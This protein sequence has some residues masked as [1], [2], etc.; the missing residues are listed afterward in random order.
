MCRRNQLRG[1]L[2]LGIGIGMVIGYCVNSWL[3]C[4]CG[5][6]A[7]AVTAVCMMKNGI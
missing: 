4:C 7:L 3:I 2:L 6:I 1:C 5:G